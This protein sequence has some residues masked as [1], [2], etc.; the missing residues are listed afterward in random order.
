MLVCKFIGEIGILFLRVAEDVDPY[1]CCKYLFLAVTLVL[2]KIYGGVLF[3]IIMIA[4]GVDV[5]GDPKN[6]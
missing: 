2:I 3:N 6:I 5:L 4:V 1:K